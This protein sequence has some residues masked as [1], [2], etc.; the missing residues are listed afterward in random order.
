[1]IDGPRAGLILLDIPPGT[2]KH[3][4]ASLLE[5]TGHPV[6]VCSDRRIGRVLPSVAMAA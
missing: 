1:V 3:F 5:R 6:A 4:D 2:N